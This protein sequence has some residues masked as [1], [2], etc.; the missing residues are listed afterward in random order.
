[1]TPAAWPSGQQ[2][3]H[4][5]A[6][7]RAEIE[8]PIVYIHSDETVGLGAV[9][10]AA[11]L[12]GVVQR[13]VAMFEP[14]VDAFLEQ[15][16][17]VAHRRRAQV[18]ANGVGPQRQRQAGLVVPPVAQ[19]DDQLQ[20]AIAIGELPF[21]NDQAGVDRLALILARLDRIENLVERHDHVAEVRPRHIRSAR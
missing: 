11:V 3:V 2:L 8:R 9:E 7:A 6:A 5:F 16:V 13:F 12:Q 15:P 20:T 18:F 19:V 14:V 17:H 10:I 4:R 1:M 21:M